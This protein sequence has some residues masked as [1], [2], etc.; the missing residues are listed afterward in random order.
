MKSLIRIL[1][2]AAA[3]G[4]ALAASVYRAEPVLAHPSF[5][6][7]FRVR[8]PQANGSK[9]TDPPTPLSCPAPDSHPDCTLMCHRTGRGTQTN[10]S[11][12]GLQ[13]RDRL[14]QLVPEG[15]SIQAAT[16]DQIDLALRAL[17]GHVAGGTLLIDPV[18]ATDSD[19]DGVSNIVEIKKSQT[20]PGDPNDRPR[21]GD[22]VTSSAVVLADSVPAMLGPF[23]ITTTIDSEPPVTTASASASGW[24]KA[25]KVTIAL[26]TVDPGRGAGV[27][28]IA[29][30]LS[31]AQ[32]GMGVIA[33][34]AGTVEV[35]AEGVTTVTYFATDA[36]GNVEA[37]KSLEVRIDRSPPLLSGLPAAGCTLWP[38]DHRLVDVAS[39]SAQDALSGVARGS[40]Q[41]T[42]QSNEA[43]YGL[44]L[45][46]IAP[47]VVIGGGVVRL[48]A[49][50]SDRGPGR[51]YVI[52]AFARD[53]AGNESTGTAT[54]FVP[55]DRVG[56]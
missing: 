54:C 20:F 41:V 34:H 37:P 32:T 27:K 4:L 48:R 44:G 55:H 35:V 39:V 46:D 21:A 43:E 19:G 22:T 1:V 25:S 30:R 15:Q 24:T 23:P 50:R 36:F 6:C 28:E 33:G 31:G 26:S 5:L 2:L 52:S 9:L 3:A 13:F 12:Y 56:R 8:Y 14:R 40:F 17:E 42:A 47:D 29:L 11:I 45:G 38:A 10:L 53:V 16:P 7:Q 49:E 18:G 51:L